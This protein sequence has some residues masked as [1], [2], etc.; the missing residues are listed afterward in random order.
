MKTQAE[1][2]KQIV[3]ERG[4]WDGCDVI[5]IT[6]YCPGCKYEEYCRRLLDGNS[7][8]ARL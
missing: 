3:A 4:Q 7:N 5:E 2:L 1:I 6:E 8:D